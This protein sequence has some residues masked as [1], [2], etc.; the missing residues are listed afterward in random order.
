VEEKQ[1]VPANWR[2]L[3]ARWQEPRPKTPESF[4]YRMIYEENYKHT[5]DYWP[6]WMPRWSP[7]TDDPSAR[8]LAP[9]PAGQ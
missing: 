7:E 4:W 9:Q 1:L 3:A 2:D 6:F 5:G 8:T